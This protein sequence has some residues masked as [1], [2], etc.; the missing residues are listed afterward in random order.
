MWLRPTHPSIFPLTDL[1]LGACSGCAKGSSRLRIGSP[2]LWRCVAPGGSP[3][4]SQEGRGEPAPCGGTGRGLPPRHVAQFGAWLAPMGRPPLQARAA[5]PQPGPGPPRRAP[6]LQVAL[7]PAF[8]YFSLF[9]I[10]SLFVPMLFNFY[11][12]AEHFAEHSSNSLYLLLY[13]LDRSSICLFLRFLL[14]SYM[15]IYLHMSLA[16]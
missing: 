4:R 6:P 9:F 1:R 14:C 8:P 10:F 16:R 3:C 13:H 15:Y 12:Y 5:H 7:L 2:G 11:Q